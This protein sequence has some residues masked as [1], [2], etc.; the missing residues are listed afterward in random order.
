MNF[1][2]STKKIFVAGHNGMVGRAVC[3]KLSAENY[4]VITID[5][6]DLDLRDQSEVHKYIKFTKPDLVVICAAKVGGILANQTYPAEF[7]YENIMIQ[8]N[9]IHASHLNEVQDLIFLGS[10]CIYPVHANI[11]IDE[12]ALL[13]GKLEPTN[14]AYAI[15]KISGLKMCQAYNKQYGR[16]YKTLQPSNLYGPY[17]NFNSE[18]SH[19]IPGLMSRMHNAKTNNNPVFDVWGNGKPLREFLHVNDLASAVDLLISSKIPND[20]LNVGSGVEISIA[21]L[22]RSI[23]V[24]IGY[25]GSIKFL[26]EYPSGT[27]RKKLNS[28]KIRGLGWKPNIELSN[29][30][31]ETYDWFLQKIDK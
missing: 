4:N 21:E 20:V 28:D 18:T 8:A 10:S 31:V 6:N 7:I 14:E 11:P 23:Q 15:A 16:N 26:S 19:V 12:D 25:Q 5:R 2:K 29:G 1:D 24:V 9:V 17:D 22:V 30:L 3:Q 13:S 27:Y